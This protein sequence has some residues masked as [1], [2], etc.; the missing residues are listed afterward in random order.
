MMVMMGHI[1]GDDGGLEDQTASEYGDVKGV[2]AGKTELTAG[3]PAKQCRHALV[4]MGSLWRK[5]ERFRPVSGWRSGQH[6]IALPPWGGHARRFESRRPPGT[7]TAESDLTRSVRKF[8]G[9]LGRRNTNRQS[10]PGGIRRTMLSAWGTDHPFATP[11]EGFLF[12]FSQLLQPF[13][14]RD[15]SPRA[16]HAHAKILVPTLIYRCNRHLSITAPCNIP[17]RQLLI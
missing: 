2:A 10:G 5:K 1:S 6:S 9:S 17:A 3:K 11:K 15:S 16:Q 8:K 13:M 12:C 4:R 7:V 14:G